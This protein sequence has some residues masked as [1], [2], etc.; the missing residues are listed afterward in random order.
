MLFFKK[1]SQIFA[2]SNGVNLA[3]DYRVLEKYG[4]TKKCVAIA[5]RTINH[6]I[7]WV[8]NYSLILVQNVISHVKLQ[9]CHGNLPY[10]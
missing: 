3:S 8:T 1:G 5:F 6:V 4:K 9:N 10:V 7:S 2:S